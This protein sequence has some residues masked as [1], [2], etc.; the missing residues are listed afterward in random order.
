MLELDTGE[1]AAQRLAWLQAL[2]ISVPA[3]AQQLNGGE[4]V[5][6]AIPVDALPLPLPSLWPTL[7]DQAGRPD[8]ARLGATH[9][10]ALLYMG[11]MSLDSETL[12][13]LASHPQ[14]LDLDSAQAGTFAAF[15]RSIRVRGNRIEP[16]G[17]GAYAPIWVQLVDRR[18]D[19][20]VEFMRRLLGRDDGRLAFLYDTVAHATEAQQQALLAGATGT[21]AQLDVVKRIYES[22]KAVDPA[23]KVGLQPFRRP[24]MDPSLALALLDLDETGVVGPPWWPQI[25]ETIAEDDGWPDR[26]IRALT[27][28]PATL[29]WAFGWIFEAKTPDARFR[30]LRFAQRRFARAPKTSAAVVEVALR[31]MS[32]MPALLL[33][34]E[35]L[36]VEDASVLAEVANAARRLTTSGDVEQVGP[37]LRHWQSA[38]AIFEQ[39]ARRRTIPAQT[40]DG[41][42]L[43]LAKVVPTDGVLESAAVAR[44]VIEQLNPALGVPPPADK[45]FEAA[46]I[47]A[48]LA[49]AS[50]P[51][52]TLTWEGLTYR[53]DRVGP[54]V[55]D[56]IAVRAGARGP[57]LEHL[58]VLV[59]IL[60][61]MEGGVTTLARAK[62]IVSRLEGV[63]TAMLEPRD[64]QNKPVYETE[65]LE[66]AIRTIARIQRDRDLTR[67]ARQVGKLR[68][69]VNVVTERVLPALAY[70]LAAAPNPQPQIYADSALRHLVTSAAGTPP[71]R[72]RESA[73]SLPTAGASPT[74]SMGV[75]GAMLGLDTVLAEGQ[76]RRLPAADASALPVA[77]KFNSLDHDAL[78][79]R[80]VH[81][82]PL[83]DVESAARR[84]VEMLAAGATRWADLTATSS[85][86]R[87]S[88]E[89]ALYPVLGET[90]A[91]LVLWLR[92]RQQL[93][94]AAEMLLPTERVRLGTD[95]RLPAALGMAAS[96]FDGCLCLRPPAAK[97]ILEWVG[98]GDS[99]HLSVLVVDLQLRLVEAL[100]ELK[101]PMYL[102]ELLLPMALQ[103]TFDRVGQ[104][105]PED[106]E[107]VAVARFILNTRVEE[108]LL[109]LVA[110]GILAP[111]S[112]PVQVGGH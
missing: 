99:G 87:P 102:V 47:A 88:A 112:V 90:R 107:T 37:V 15:G 65:D 30:L 20:P 82:T 85:A 84:A 94:A 18:L 51:S 57:T 68:Y 10:S 76:L 49:P 5:R 16:A 106:W 27:D 3:L 26:P 95:A 109:A 79:M 69:T 60:R 42:L 86:A 8:I 32:R 81:A 108:Y 111:P 33:A 52:Q 61:D 64:D 53:V 36:G 72:W 58:D 2:G 56:A 62:D 98:R 38:L 110:E 12:A 39:I 71:E 25:L 9:R 6:L 97:P 7:L 21:Q 11:L 23:W 105:S 13:F 63:R 22:S 78:T 67:V 73:W 100:S 83:D 4:R 34:L 45:R 28:R 41:L 89:A 17:G 66:D 46:A 75:L 1:D 54:V 40:R 70:A 77:G 19:E 101:L 31:G 44:W 96:A 35:R 74:G 48:W 80:L 103:D 59:R 14:A 50:A 91:N 24:P 43:A 55:R 104:F 29:V 92:E 93:E